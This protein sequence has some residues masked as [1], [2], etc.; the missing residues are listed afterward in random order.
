MASR[1]R[2]GEPVLPLAF[3]EAGLPVHPALRRALSEAAG[4]NGYGPVAGLTELRE[5][6]AGYWSRRGLPT[7]PDAVICGPG[8][9]ALLF[10][11][12]LAIGADVAVPQPSWVSYAAQVNLTGTTAQFVPVPPG[13]G[14]VPDADL[15]ADAA[16]RARASGRRI[17]AVVV[18]LPDNPTGRLA[19]P[20]AVRALCEVAAAQN[21]II[22]SDEIYRDLVHDPG[23]PFVSPAAFA[24]ERTIVTTALSKS[25]ALGGWRIGVARLPDGALPDGALPGRN[26]RADGTSGP[27]TLRHTLRDRLLGIGS[28]IWSAPSGPIQQA[29]AFAFREPPELTAHIAL[30]RRLHASVARAIAARF[31]AAGAIVPQPQAAFYVYPDFEPTRDLL[32]RRHG[33]TTA[34]ALAALLL[35]RYGMGVLPGSA[36]GEDSQALR[37]RIATSQLYGQH[38]WQRELA[39][40][41]A[42]PLCLPWI[43]SAL[44]RIDDVLTDLTA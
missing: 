32:R 14:G 43:A 35:R 41:S 11:L 16:T 19:T 6:A 28:E 27:G 1:Q 23:T 36:F 5:A 30:S 17:R 22:I 2:R 44:T 18:T 33:V 10:G 4:R 20:E 3:G 37:L 21:M 34:E 39:L 31:A 40:N 24:P 25:L 29:A 42:A 38:D 13:Q 7:H 26:T 9:K 12:V 8:S 15:L